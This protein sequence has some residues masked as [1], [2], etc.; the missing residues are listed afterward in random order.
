[1]GCRSYQ[2]KQSKNNM[3]EDKKT[4]NLGL[5][6]TPE[7]SQG[8]YSNLVVISHSPTEIILD[9]AQMLPGNEHA[10]VRTRSIMHPVHAK[11]LLHALTDN[12]EK[13][14]QQYGRIVEIQGDT[15]PFDMIP[16]GEA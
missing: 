2:V 4:Q 16:Q 8:H 15:V 3:K 11:R 7:V 9:F 1:M 13:Y 6:I 5:D 12:I 10:V 14:E